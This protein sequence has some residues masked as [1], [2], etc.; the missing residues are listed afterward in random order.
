MPP[1]DLPRDA[2]V[3]D[4][5]H[6]AE[7]VVRPLLGDQADLSR[8]DGLDRRLGERLDLHEPLRRQIGLHHRLAAVAFA[9]RHGVVLDLGQ[10]SALLQRF[11]HEG[12]G[13]L[14]RLGRE[15]LAKRLLRLCF[16]QAG[17]IH[18]RVLIE[19][20]QPGQIVTEPRL[21]VVEVMSGRDLDRAGAEF[22]IDENGISHNRDAALGQRQCNALAD[23]SVVAGVFGVDGDAGVAQ[24]GFGPR[25]GHREMRCRV[26]R[27]RVT[28]V[29]Q[30]AGGIFMFHLDIGKGGEAAGAPVDQPLPP[31]DQAVLMKP[32]E[33]LAHG[34]RQAVVHREPQPVPV[35]RRAQP[36]ELLDDR[37]AGLRFPV[38]HPLDEP[39]A[40]ELVARGAFR[41]QLLL[42]HV[43]RGDA[44]MVGPRHPQG[45]PALH[46]AP[47]DQDILDG[48][49]QGMSHVQ[50]AGD[51]G[52]GNDDHV[53]TAFRRRGGMEITAFGPGPV[54]ACLNLLRIVGFFHGALS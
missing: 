40:A 31:V 23:Q 20:G 18:A 17:R 34:L 8:F 3:L 16:A 50:G 42:H 36:F 28:D 27:K 33:H 46:A 49:V 53:G 12:S 35:A 2:P 13:L 48:V 10:E 44:C 41:Q 11:D 37:A 21:E 47:A 5:P 30:L 39:V 25:R 14:D 26:I 1:P 4:V 15:A 24:H 43:L 9:E 19:D 38:P 22:P 52:R 6:P 51:V 45:V 7:V 32:D 54:P 29:V